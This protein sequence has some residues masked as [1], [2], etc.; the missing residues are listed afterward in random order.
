MFYSSIM[1]GK[2]DNSNTFYTMSLAPWSCHTS[3]LHWGVDS[4][5]EMFIQ[6]HD[7]CPKNQ[8]LPFPIHIEHLWVY[9]KHPLCFQKNYYVFF[10]CSLVIIV[11]FYQLQVGV[12]LTLFFFHATY[13]ILLLNSCHNSLS[14]VYTL[15]IVILKID[16]SSTIS[17]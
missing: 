5:K 8:P 16:L 3:N 11:F 7:V 12:P 13:Q 1:V 15:A 10:T 9:G 17:I 14:S 4:T 6:L 2:F